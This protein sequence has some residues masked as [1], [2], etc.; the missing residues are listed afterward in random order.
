[1]G[2]FYTYSF[3]DYWAV[4]TG[5]QMYCVTHENA[6]LNSNSGNAPKCSVKPSAVSFIAFRTLVTRSV[7]NLHL[8]PQGV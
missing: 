2:G 4:F 1:M 3:T 5:R 7:L 6:L 8:K